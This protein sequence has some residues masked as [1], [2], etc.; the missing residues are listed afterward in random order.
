[1][2]LYCNALK[3]TKSAGGSSD[4]VLVLIGEGGG[5]GLSQ[6]QLVFI[7]ILKGE[8]AALILFAV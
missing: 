2:V 4:L 8:P 6:G 3:R 5:A 7:S 1:M